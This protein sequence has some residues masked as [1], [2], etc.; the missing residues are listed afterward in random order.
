MFKKL[1]PFI[2]LAVIL[3]V[4]ISSLVIHPDIRGHNLASYF[5]SQ[6]N[7]WL[8]FYDHLSK[9]PRQ[10]PLVKLYTDGLF[11]YPPLAY[12]THA[13]FMKFTFPFVSHDT[14]WRLIHDM[15]S[16]TKNKD[17]F[18]LLVTLKLPYLVADII[19]LFILNKILDVKNR[20]WGSIVWLF[21]PI[22]LYSAYMIGQFDIYI[23][24]FIFLGILAMSKKKTI[25]S[26]VFMGLASLY[27]PFP[28]FLLPLLG[29]NTKDK[30]KATAAGVLTYFLGILPFVLT[31][32]GFKNYALLASQ[33]DKITYAK[34][35]VSGSQYIPLFYL[36]LILIYWLNFYKPKLLSP[37]VWLVSPLLLFY[38]VT[39]FH[40]QW[41]TWSAGLLTLIAVTKRK[42]VLPVL[43]LVMLYFLIILT[44]EP[45]LN[46][47]LF[48]INF[49]FFDWLNPRFPADQ[50]VSM[51]RGGIF[52]T[53]LAVLI[54]L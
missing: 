2:I 11:I 16:L 24:M 14:F 21:N 50:F 34:I 8:T 44:F 43:V 4:V 20:F 13:I 5:I 29:E 41:F 35:M 30:V 23:T 37:V 6:Q 25:L 47:G 53:S 1:F 45:S 27:K 38:S 48:G 31:S 26:G 12:Y 28:L 42:S 54:S 3:R 9:L 49:N 17:L 15:G 7:E 40:P 19:S 18:V 10:D 52:A 46:F 36:G 22:T 32:P 39:H 51:L 33:T